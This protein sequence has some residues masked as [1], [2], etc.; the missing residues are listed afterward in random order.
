MGWIVPTDAGT[1]RVNWRDPAGKQ[2]AK[3]LPTKKEA[4]AF[5]A[6]VEADASRGTYVDPHAGRVL[7][8]DYAADWL[9]GRT[10][11]ARTQENTEGMLRTHV[12]P[13]W[14]EWPLT[15]VDHLS[16]QQWVAELATRRKPATV[17]AA[18]GV[19]SM[20]LDTAVRARLLPINPCDGVR[21]PRRRADASP[22]QTI[23]RDELHAKL[24]PAVPEQYRVLVCLAAGAG[25]R[26][27]ECAGLAWPAVDL[28]A[29]EVQ[30]HQ[31]AVETS[32]PIVLRAYPKSRAGVR[33]VPLPRFAVA[34]L[35]EHRPMSTHPGNLVVATRTGTA[36]RRST[37]RRR[38]WVQALAAAGLQPTLRF[39]DL[40][41]SYATW[42]VTD[43][44]P[45]NI[46]QR[47]MG[48]EQAS[49]T[50]NRYVHAPRDYDARVRE[51][52]DDEEPE[53]GR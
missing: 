7:L 20:I 30:V 28:D 18:L 27:G 10:V 1:Y 4:K 33:R 45:V 34:A 38:V 48:H 25:L 49:T 6:R 23:T 41:H 12:L 5:L 17:V 46:V 39:H 16:V 14:G 29:R 11:E 22:M 31:V 3:T 53:D 44:V 15:K 42:L 24:L 36:L 52:F 26:W 19:L 9:A 47:L 35:R 13:R 50:L 21:A 40:R 8:R 37:F 32:G 2:R 43:G 51:L